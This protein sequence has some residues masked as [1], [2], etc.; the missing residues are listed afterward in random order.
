MYY[1]TCTCFQWLHL[2]EITNSHDCLYKW[3]ESLKL[4]RV[5]TIAFVIMPNHFC[6]SGVFASRPRVF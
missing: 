1:L 6:P 4:K 3:F 2:F 5:D